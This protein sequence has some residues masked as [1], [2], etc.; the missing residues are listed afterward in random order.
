MSKVEKWNLLTVMIALMSL[1]RNQILGR[2]IDWMAVFFFIQGSV[3][4]MYGDEIL[5]WFWARLEEI[6]ESDGRR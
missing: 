4:F 6:G 3:F 2:P 1:Y 5:E